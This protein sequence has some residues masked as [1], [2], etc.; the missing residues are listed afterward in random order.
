MHVVKYEDLQAY[1]LS[2]DHTEGASVDVIV[3]YLD[4]YTYTGQIMYEPYARC[5]RCYPKQ[6]NGAQIYYDTREVQAYVGC[7]TTES[8]GYA[9]DDIQFGYVIDTQQQQE[10][11]GYS[12]SWGIATTD[13]SSY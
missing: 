1:M 10:A 12:V 8:Y 3:N 13:Y 6:R 9:V 4:K 7:G 2:L 5:W 11:Q